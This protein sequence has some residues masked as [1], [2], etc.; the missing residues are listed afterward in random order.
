MGASFCIPE[1]GSDLFLVN[2][3]AIVGRCAEID[4]TIFAIIF[5]LIITL[6]TVSG[7]STAY[8]KIGELVGIGFGMFI[9]L[10]GA[11]ILCM[12]RCY[13]N[14]RIVEWR[15]IQIEKENLKESGKNNSQIVDYFTRREE[16]RERN[17]TRLQAASTLSNAI[18]IAG[19]RR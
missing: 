15:R 12:R 11:L 19:Q 13:R 7:I 10:G 16:E 18:I 17:E 9:L 8:A 6:G 14:S 1:C 4:G 2:D 3:E 5:S